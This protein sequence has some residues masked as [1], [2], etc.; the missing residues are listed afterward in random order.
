MK[1]AKTNVVMVINE[2]R[3][4]MYEYGRRLVERG[5]IDDV[6]EVFMVTD[7][8]LDQLRAD[9]DSFT[10]VISDRWAQ[11]RELF[12]YEPVFIVNGRV[13]SLDEMT[14]DGKDVG[15]AI[16][17][18]VLT[19]AAGS[20]APRAVVPGSSSTWPTRRASSPATCSLRPRPTRRGAL[21]VSAAAVVVN[22]GREATR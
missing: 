16:E 5:V 22:V 3:V 9:P 4:A 15:T 2:V 13:P 21:F 7:E 10:T 1:R 12:D 11:Y 18:T 20:G 17:G 14:D 6:Q 8:E 19:G